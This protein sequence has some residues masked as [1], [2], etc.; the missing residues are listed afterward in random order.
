MRRTAEFGVFAALAALLHIAALRAFDTGAPVA[1]GA[2][3]S[4]SVA[5]SGATA[6]LSELIASWEQPPEKGEVGDLAAAEPNDAAPPPPVD[7][8]TANAAPGPDRAEPAPRRDR[9]F[10]A[11]EANRTEPPDL[12]DAGLP[13]TLR[14]P[15]DP[16]PP[17]HPAAALALPEIPQPTPLPLPPRQE[18]IPRAAEP[19]PRPDRMPEI[20][21]PLPGRSPEVE[22]AIDPATTPRRAPA[23]AAPGSVAP[24]DVGALRDS[25]PEP[26]PEPGPGPE[27]DPA[28]VVAVMP[29]PRP[30]GPK[31]T[32]RQTVPPRQTPARAEPQAA[33]AARV[34]PGR[35]S[36]PAKE[37]PA[38][39]AP[40]SPS[41]G[42]DAARLPA[43]GKA[44]KGAGVTAPSGG[45]SATDIA[46]ARQAWL[47]EVRQSVQR[48]KRYPRQAG[49][50]GI[51]GQSTVRI[52]LDANGR[53]L[54]ATLAGSSGEAI[55]DEAAL[56]A[57]RG[58]GRYPP[59]PPEMRQASVTITLP[60]DFRRR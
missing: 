30:E 37:P 39:S 21:T 26:E 29:E 5:M 45:Y 38:D 50:R 24:A 25:E 47:A 34:D 36:E 9:A 56:A 20:A 4:G 35:Q 6:E 42:W 2:P 23:L 48:A 19:E 17:A 7:M 54:D 57:V 31:V 12:P 33:A 14:S 51:E 1:A 43:T 15:P 53:L 52:T 58:V 40:A 10:V 22:P 46:S 55:L 11:P 44:G 49:R 27:P 8:S 18:E 59:I 3:G 16:A 60:F 41:G 28:P 32:Q 13:P